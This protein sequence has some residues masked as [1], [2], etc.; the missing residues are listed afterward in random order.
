MS[1]NFLTK[2]L[3]RRLWTE[4]LFDW[5]ETSCPTNPTS[6]LLTGARPVMTP[7]MIVGAASDACR[8]AS[9]SGGRVNHFL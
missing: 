2:I 5:S 7:S 6:A 9:R 3:G 1:C 4:S 8:H